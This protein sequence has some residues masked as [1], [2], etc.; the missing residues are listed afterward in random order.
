MIPRSR[1]LKKFLKTENQPE[2]VAWKT[3]R[4]QRGG[5]ERGREERIGEERTGEGGEGRGGKYQP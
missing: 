1:S 4:E 5:E 3:G 2:E